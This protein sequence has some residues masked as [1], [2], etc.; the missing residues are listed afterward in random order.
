MPAS[1]PLMRYT[2]RL[3]TGSRSRYVQHPDPPASIHR[4][5]RDGGPNS[6][7][8]N[9]TKTIEPG[10]HDK[11][12]PYTVYFIS[13]RTNIPNLTNRETTVARRYSDF[14]YFRDLLERRSARVTIPTLP[15]K[16]GF[17]TDPLSPEIVNHRKEKLGEFVQNVASHPLL[18]TQCHD[19][20]VPFIQGK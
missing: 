8:I 16:T 1:K 5:K 10:Q 4:A 7:K 2:V 3:R 13:C 11:W 17:L 19:L 18:L 6:I 14:E 9:E 15:G 12:R 20:V